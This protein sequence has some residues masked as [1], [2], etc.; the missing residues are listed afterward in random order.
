MRSLVTSYDHSLWLHSI[1]MSITFKSYDYACLEVENLMLRD[2]ALHGF[3]FIR[4]HFIRNLFCCCL[5]ILSRHLAYS[6][7]LGLHVD[8]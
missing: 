6:A 2:Y 4:N 7:N 5:F 1:I 3:Y 8:D